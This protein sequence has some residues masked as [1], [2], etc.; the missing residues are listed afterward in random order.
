MVEKELHRVSQT[1]QLRKTSRDDPQEETTIKDRPNSEDALSKAFTTLHR[2]EIFF[3]CCERG[4]DHDLRT[5]EEILE[6]DPKKQINI[7]YNFLWRFT[8]RFLRDK[9]DP[10]HILNKKN[11]FGHTPLYVASKN[12][13]FAVLYQ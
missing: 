12:G 13:N 3:E 8:S 11:V 1:A 9:T 5:M 2:N 4:E 7:F 6:S 10:E